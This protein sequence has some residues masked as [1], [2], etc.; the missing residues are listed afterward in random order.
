MKN[1]FLLI[2]PQTSVVKNPCLVHLTIISLFRH[3]FPCVPDVVCAVGRFKKFGFVLSEL[4]NDFWEK[5]S[6]KFLYYVK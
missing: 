6:P 4:M 5:M 1:V 3:T 2:K